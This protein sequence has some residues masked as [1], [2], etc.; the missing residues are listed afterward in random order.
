M[1]HG[2]RVPDA[3]RAHE[4]IQGSALEHVD[5]LPVQPK[6]G[7][8]KA[9]DYRDETILEGYQALLSECYPDDRVALTVFPSKM[10]YGGPREAVFDAIVRK[11]QGCT[12]FVVDRDHAGVGD[13]YDGFDAHDIFDE[14]GRFGIE[15]VFF[16]YAFY[17]RTCDGMTSEK[18]CPRDLAVQDP[19][20]RDDPA[21]AVVTMGGSDV[22]GLTPAAVRAFDDTDVRVE[23]AIG[24]G[25]SAEQV[26]VVEGAANDLSAVVE[27]VRD[28]PD[29]PERL[30]Q[31]DLAVTTAGTVYE[32][33]ALGDA[34]RESGGRQQPVTYRS[35]ATRP[36]CFCGPR[37]RG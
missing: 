3:K 7:E 2:R 19:P 14:V 20:W 12:H 28:P 24:P 33:M 32:C 35:D 8:K 25:C 6:L 9:G 23:A 22:A 13:C 11:N 4:Y 31:A 21:R 17:C 26:A 16:T 5:G 1:G 10:R 37:P 29:L 30:F 18:V 15:P 36:R 34:V 27:V